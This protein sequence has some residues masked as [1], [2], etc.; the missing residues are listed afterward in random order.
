MALHSGFQSVM[1]TFVFSFL[2][3]A[4]LLLLAPSARPDLAE[5]IMLQGDQRAMEHQR[6]PAHSVE[7]RIGQKLQMIGD[8]FYQEHMLVSEY[9]INY[10]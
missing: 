6:R 1:L 3:S 8:Q 10:K 5:D 7:A 2:G 9:H 4:G